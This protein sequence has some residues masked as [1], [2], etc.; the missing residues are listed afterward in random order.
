MAK[1]EEKPK[2]PEEQAAENI[3]TATLSDALEDYNEFVN[4]QAA[5]IWQYDE[6]PVD[7]LNLEERL[8]VRSYIID[9]NP[10]SAMRRLGHGHD[11][12]KKLKA[13]AQRYLAKPAVKDAVDYLAGRMMEKLDVTAE[14]VQRQLAAAAFFDPRE[15]MEFDKFGVRLLNSRFWTAEQ[16]AAIKKIKMGTNGIEIEM[17]DR[18]KATELLAKQLGSLPEDT[19]PA[20]AAKAGAE[21]AVRKIFEV[22]DRSGIDSPP[23]IAAPEAEPPTVQ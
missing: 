4:V 14:R 7:D 13:I 12:A 18:L 5:T 16:A 19:N 11:D 21:A 1:K 2:S 6:L 23:A 20:E 9:R 17:Y 8:F 3:D 15:V 10:V 22:F